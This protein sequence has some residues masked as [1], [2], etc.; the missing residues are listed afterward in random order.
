M[1]SYRHIPQIFVSIRYLFG[2]Y[3]VPGARKRAVT[4]QKIPIFAY[5]LSHMV[6]GETRLQLNH[7]SLQALLHTG[8]II[9]IL[10]MRKLEL[11]R[12]VAEQGPGPHSSEG[13]GQWP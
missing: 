9:H 10:Q 5:I 13:L 3:C 7:R 6:A 4:E 11:S 2:T 12:S 1:G 8:I